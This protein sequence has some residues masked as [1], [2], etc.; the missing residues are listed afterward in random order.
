M[1]SVS[2]VDVVT[3]LVASLRNL[4]S[5]LVGITV[6]YA[7]QLPPVLDIHSS[8]MDI[9]LFCPARVSLGSHGNARSLP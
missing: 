5:R 3:L 7:A 4:Y 8:R 1:Y 2:E 9:D 6:I